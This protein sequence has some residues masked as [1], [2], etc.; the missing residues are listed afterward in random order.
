MR[1]VVVL[2]TVFFVLPL[3]AATDVNEILTKARKALGVPATLKSLS[4]EGTKRVAVQTP[5]GPGSMSRES[6]MSFLLPDKFQRAETI[7]LPNG[8]GTGPT[9]L[10]TLDGET[11]WRD[12]R[13]AP[14][15]ANIMIR[16][17]PA[18]GTDGSGPAADQARTRNIRALYLRN[19]LLYTL[20]PPPGIDVHFESTGEAESPEGKVW[21]VDAKG[22][23]KFELRLYIDQKTSLPVMASWRGMQAAAPM[24]R[25]VRMEAGHA[26][27]KPGE[28]PPG[29]MPDMP[30]P[31]EVEFEAKLAD[32]AKFGGLLVPKTITL[33]VDGKTTEEFELK[34][35]KV[36]PNIKAEKFRK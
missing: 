29:G 13:N 1:F 20:T 26:P 4:L 11:S 10:E 15:G 19:L 35:A 5:D 6:E 21:I 7:E 25:T 12:T 14:S 24:M 18:P 17:M 16:T 31:K 34:T 23:D 22:P 9:V 30:K 28:P 3:S 33:S 36:N 27:P 2:A 32:H 8:M